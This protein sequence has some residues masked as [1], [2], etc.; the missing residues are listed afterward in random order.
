[1][2]NDKKE[3][4]KAKLNAKNDLDK[5]DGFIFISHSKKGVSK[6][7]HTVE[8]NTIFRLLIED[9]L[10]NRYIKEKIDNINRESLREYKMD[11]G[12]YFG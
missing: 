6:R 8:Y 11:G 5:C 2:K 1:M 9:E 10:F 12:D 7:I 3:F 4:E